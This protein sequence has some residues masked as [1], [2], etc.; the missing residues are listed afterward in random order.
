M[1][2]LRGKKQ[3]LQSSTSL[4]ATVTCSA[5]SPIVGHSLSPSSH[6]LPA[7]HYSTLSRL[8]T[9]QLSLEARSR[10]PGLAVTDRKR[11]IRDGVLEHARARRI[12]RGWTGGDPCASRDNIG[13]VPCCTGPCVSHSRTQ[14][15]S[16]SNAR[17]SMQTKLSNQPNIWTTNTYMQLLLHVTR[18]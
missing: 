4:S 2:G 17:E 6:S 11:E 9:T 14:F 13:E 16:H 1:G 15:T 12:Y 3:T 5:W 8:P 7:A 10:S 18:Q